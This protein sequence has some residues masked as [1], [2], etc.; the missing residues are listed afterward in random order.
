MRWRWSPSIFTPGSLL[1]IQSSAPRIFANPAR[2]LSDG[3]CVVI[4]LQ[5][6]H[7]LIGRNAHGRRAD[8]N[9]EGE[10]IEQHQG[11]FC[12]RLAGAHSEKKR[13]LPCSKK[14]TRGASRDLSVASA[15]LPTFTIFSPISACTSQGGPPSRRSGI[16]P[17]TV[18]SEIRESA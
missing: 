3:T 9:E 13:D 4:V 15:R 14:I 7:T 6:S 12:S 5:I 18:T 17:L 10:K 8:L 1:S 2:T 11:K 16:S